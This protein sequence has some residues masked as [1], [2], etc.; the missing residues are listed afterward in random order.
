MK[1][2]VVI[3]TEKEVMKACMDSVLAQD[4]PD[5]DVMVHV[6]RRAFVCDD[7]R[8]EPEVQA[9]ITKYVNCAENRERARKMAL[10]SDAEKFLFVDSD[11]LLTSGALSELVKQNMDVIAGWYKVQYEERYTC[12]RWVADNL[13]LNL[14]AVERS[15]VKVDSFGMGCALFS[16]RALTDVHFHHGTDMWA[17]TIIG[18]QESNFIVG[19]C[20]AV[21]GLLLDKGY[22]PY[23]D[24]SVVCEH[25]D[26]AAGLQAAVRASAGLAASSLP[27]AMDQTDA[28]RLMAT[29]A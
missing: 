1:V 22:Q 5:F 23:M 28:K 14:W 12:G 19:E 10:A 24:G 7:S 26:R 29:S 3:I 17:K 25:L 4:C 6:H 20:G 11:I 27:M 8:H 9:A 15:V 18:G 13:F 2:L 21:G 16:R